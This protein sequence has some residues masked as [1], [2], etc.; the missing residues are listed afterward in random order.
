MT[1]TAVSC[2]TSDVMC[3]SLPDLSLSTPKHRTQ[4]AVGY[5]MV[6]IG[7]AIL[8]P[9]LYF[10]AF[11]GFEREPHNAIRF[12]S[13]SHF[14]AAWTDR[15]WQIAVPMILMDVFRDTLLPTAVYTTFVYLFLVQFLP[16]VGNWVD[17]GGRLMVQQVSN[18]MENACVIATSI[19]F[20]WLV[21]E[22]PSIGVT[23]PV[24]DFNMVATFV[25]LIALGCLGELFNNASTLAIEKDWVVVL[26]QVGGVD[27]T[28]INTNMRRIDLSCKALAPAGFTI[29]YSLFSEPRERIFYGSAMLVLWNV[30]SFPLE[31]VFN[32]L[33]FASCHELSHKVHSHADGTTH[34]HC[35]GDKP[36]A[37]FARQ[38]ATG[39]V[40]IL[41]D[42]IEPATV[43]LY[44]APPDSVLVGYMA[45]A[46]GQAAQSLRTSWKVYRQQT[47]FWASVAYTALWM[48]VLDNGALMTSYLQWRGVPVY[49]LG[50]GRGT[51]ACFG[52]V[53]TVAF[54]WLKRAAGSVEGTGLAGVWLFFLLLCP[55]GIAFALASHTAVADYTLLWLVS[56]SRIGLWTFDLAIT[57]ISQETVP[58]E[59]RG[60]VGS[61]QVASYQAF[62]VMIQ[63]ITMLNAD[64]RNFG[65]LVFFSCGVVGAAALLYSYWLLTKARGHEEGETTPLNAANHPQSTG[66]RC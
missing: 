32:Y 23:S 61:V 64:P 19:L 2:V 27:L 48:T 6:L 42:L 3:P 25:K 43:S 40:S 53:G 47:M 18:L 22:E 54:A 50:I 1:F 29:V 14:M 8:F 52:L 58:E 44:Q 21:I 41:A 13:V 45:H 12:I 51:G 4:E 38:T 7:A 28:S 35:R 11:H 16:Y 55:I 37:H 49:Y 34:S 39:E 59:S 33:A 5:A 15:S 31:Y 65:W 17:R 20:C 30:L 26:S 62:F 10:M 57:E 46:G 56:V 36:H 24:W 60:V 63:V 66:Y 9:L